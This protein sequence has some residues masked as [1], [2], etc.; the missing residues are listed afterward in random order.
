MNR[1]TLIAVLIGLV[2][3]AVVAPRASQASGSYTAGHFML[4]L[5]G[6]RALSE[7]PGRFSSAST[8]VLSG[9]S[10]T[11]AL[12]SW[13]RS[14]ERRDATVVMHPGD[15]TVAMYKMEEAWPQVAGE[16]LTL[17]YEH[18]SLNL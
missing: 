11:P 8:L 5:D 2:L 12:L 18:I 7:G 13:A 10:R 1:N 3:G 4:S 15:G 16:Q 6:H 17:N 9:G 14:G